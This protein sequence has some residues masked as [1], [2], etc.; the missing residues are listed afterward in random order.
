MTGMAE[1]R[2]QIAAILA[3][4][5]GVGVVHQYQRW[6]SEW[7]KLLDLFKHT[8][9]DGVQRING[10]MITRYATSQRKVTLGEKERAHIFLIRGVY[11]LKDEEATEHE[12][13]A[14]LE[15]AV[16]AFDE[17]E[18]V[19]LKD[20]CLTTIPD[21]GPMA[22]SAGLQIMLVEPRLFGSVLCH[23]SEC[24]ICAIERVED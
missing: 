4:V 3:A 18:N 9:G 21:W 13:Q 7:K 24:R 15:R 8:D 6:S 10:Q 5:E 17:E 19:T 16:N 11:S 22:D 23:Y 1:I 12:Y 14:I 20:T 2:E